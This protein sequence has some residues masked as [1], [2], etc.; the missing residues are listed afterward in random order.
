M[1]KISKHL[2]YDDRWAIQE[3]IGRKGGMFVAWDQ[4]VEVKQI[5]LHDFCIELRIGSKG[6]DS[7]FWIILVYA[8][9]DFRE[10]QQQWGFL[11]ARKQQWGSRWVLGG[12][13]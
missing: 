2:K 13:T 3:P 9:T 6:G 12:G 10:R 4:S 1:R 7:D 8:S 5:E 11:K